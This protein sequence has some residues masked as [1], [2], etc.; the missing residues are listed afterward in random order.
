MAH[1][2]LN[3][4]DSPLQPHHLRQKPSFHISGFQGLHIETQRV[5]SHSMHDISTRGLFR[6]SHVHAISDKQV[7]RM[8]FSAMAMSGYALP[9]AKGGEPLQV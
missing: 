6:V 2:K 8:I 4:R 9:K 7:K 3:D 1:L 5:V